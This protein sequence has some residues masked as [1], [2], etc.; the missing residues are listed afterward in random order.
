MDGQLPG[1]ASWP[2]RRAS[3]R[4]A[5]DK[6]GREVVWLQGGG[7]GFLFW[8]VAEKDFRRVMQR[9]HLKAARLPPQLPQGK[10]AKSEEI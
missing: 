3:H 2:E 7:W 8:L 5:P 1:L 9:G 10:M 4:P 6:G